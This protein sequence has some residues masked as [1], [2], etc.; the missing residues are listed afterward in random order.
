MKKALVGS[1]ALA[2]VLVAGFFAA[3]TGG[4]APRK[5]SPAPSTT[6]STTGR[7]GRNRATTTSP[8]ARPAPTHA[9]APTTTTT[10]VKP[11][12]VDPVAGAV[13]LRLQGQS[14]DAID[15]NGKVVKHLVTTFADRQV[16]RAQ[17]LGDHNT[18]WYETMPATSTNIT[19]TCDDVV[20]L[21]LAGNH[22]T[23]IAHAD[24]FSVSGD[25]R[26]VAL[27]NVL[28]DSSCVPN[29]NQGVGR[30]VVR[31]VNTGKESAI[32]GKV[33]GEVVLSPGG[34]VLVTTQCNG[35]YDDCALNMVTAAVPNEIG[36]P[37]TLQRVNDDKLGFFRL[38]A[39]NDG[40]YASVED[41]SGGCSCSGSPANILQVV[42]RFSWS[43]L[44]GTGT[45]LF[46][47]DGKHF[48]DSIAPTNNGVLA[49]E[50]RSTDSQ[51]TLDRLGPNG[52]AALQ[53]LPSDK[54]TL[55]GS[56]DPFFG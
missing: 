12:P 37:L 50:S 13:A 17:L 9:A 8:T 55:L 5:G 20:R 51:V 2:L 23:V 49:V 7:A 3:T 45:P 46:T 47:T 11:K 43:D 48:I 15:A 16:I 27:E 42:R 33:D 26:R 41:M 18:I 10:T 36:A 35:E 19:N 38:T 24:S 56:I 54:E 4:S 30:N 1:S 44:A 22:R 34:H 32:V 25:G 39:R 29:V 6:T 28:P 31:D 14:I 40:L 53:V 52:A 21:D